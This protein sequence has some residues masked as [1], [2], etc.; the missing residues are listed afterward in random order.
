MTLT[1]NLS[2]FV[3]TPRELPVTTLPSK[4]DVLSFVFFL[5]E[6]HKVG[7]K[8]PSNS[9]VFGAA[10]D[11]ILGLVLSRGFHTATKRS[12]TRYVIVI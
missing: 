12:I 1:F 10:A 4:R 2:D 5:R 9:F 3:G 6:K 7:S 8:N 11:S